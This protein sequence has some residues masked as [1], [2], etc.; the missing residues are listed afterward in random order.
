MRAQLDHLCDVA[1]ETGTTVQVI[2]FGAGA[3][4]GSGGFSY[5]A[6]ATPQ[7]DTAELESAHGPVFTHAEAELA[8]YHAHLEWMAKAALTPEQS[9]EV[10]HQLARAL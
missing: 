4:P 2:R 6:G 5:A 3:F 7:L 1:E 10:I 8:K 9:Q